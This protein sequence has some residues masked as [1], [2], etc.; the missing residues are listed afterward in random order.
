M[1]PGWLGDDR[2]TTYWT[3]LGR[4]GW[5]RQTETNCRTVLF[6]TPKLM[7]N[8]GCNCWTQQSPWHTGR[9]LPRSEIENGRKRRQIVSWLAH[10]LIDQPANSTDNRCVRVCGFFGLSDWNFVICAAS[11]FCSYAGHAN[12][13]L[14][15]TAIAIKL[16]V[17]WANICSWYPY[18]F[19]T[20]IS[21]FLGCHTFWHW[22]N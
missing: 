5:T 18:Q 13:W 20:F 17:G 12:S 14:L 7:K 22:L 6:E 4:L 10:K 3:H 19:F 9:V 1:I 2:S 8:S 16:F 21:R 11:I 15:S